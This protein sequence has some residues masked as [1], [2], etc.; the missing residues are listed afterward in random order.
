M[1]KRFISLALAMLLILGLVPTV[2]ASETTVLYV[3]TTGNDAAVGS[4][5]APLKTFK[6]A[7]ERVRE[8]KEQGVTVSEVIFRQGDYYTYDFKMTE[9]DSGT[10]ENPIVY[11]AYDGEKVAIKGSKR[12][13]VTKATQVTDEETLARMHDKAKGK[14]ISVD[15]KAQGFTEDD[16][17]DSSWANGIESFVYDKATHFDGGDYNTVFVDGS[18]LD[19]A[20]WPNGRRYTTWGKTLSDYSFTY[21]ES[22]PERWVNAKNWWIGS[23]SYYDF[24]YTTI[25]PER[26]DT[27]E[28]VIHMPTRSVQVFYNP[29]SKRWKAFNLLEELDI[30]GEYYI[31]RDSMTLYMYPPHSLANSKVEISA[32]G[33]NIIHL[34]NTEHVTFKNIEFSQSRNTGVRVTNVRNIDFLGCTFKDNGCYGLRNTGIAANRPVTYDLF[35]GKRVFNDASYDMDIKGCVFDNMGIS[36][37]WLLGGNIDTLTP[38]NN[39]IEDC[40][41]YSSANRYFVERLLRKFSL[42]LFTM[43]DKFTKNRKFLYPF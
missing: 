30:P 20:Q 36:S 38:S 11:R 43:F 3:A 41:F 16:I 12:V 14:L 31:D 35:G 33:T 17:L 8:L 2:F 27:E 22:E 10:E 7:V 29:Y 24:S 21:S 19:I 39:I 42:V 13:D 28:K 40:Y 1:K 26:I 9:L 5:E 37:I 25:T 23:F 4:I 18:E 32:T 6:G 15:L 34:T